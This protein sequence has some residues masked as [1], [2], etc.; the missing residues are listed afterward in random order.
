MTPCGSVDASITCWLSCCFLVLK[1]D[2]HSDGAMV[3]TDHD[4]SAAGKSDEA[5]REARN[6]SIIS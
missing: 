1:E 4:G 3:T 6:D 2:D 5:S